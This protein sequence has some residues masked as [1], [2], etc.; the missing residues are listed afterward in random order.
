MAALTTEH[1]SF[2]ASCHQEGAGT[3]EIVSFHVAHVANGLRGALELAILGCLWFGF[4][5]HENEVT[6]AQPRAV[7]ENSSR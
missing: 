1:L 7:I 5:A 4:T 6:S 3:E 2:D